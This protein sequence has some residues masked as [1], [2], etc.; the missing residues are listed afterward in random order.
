[1][2]IVRMRRIAIFAEG[3]TELQFLE[4]LILKIATENTVQ[5]EKRQISGGTSKP[6]SVVVLQSPGVPADEEYYVLLVDCQGDEQVRKRIGENHASLTKK[7][8]E[9]II[10]IRDVAPK[11]RREEISKLEAGLRMYIKS[12]LTPVEIF[13]TVM[14]IEAWFL[15]EHS[16]FERIDQLITMHAIKSAL[17]FDPSV[18]DTSL[19]ENPTSDLDLAYR[20]AGKGYEKGGDAK[21]MAALDY[22]MMYLELGNRVSNLGKLVSSLDAFFS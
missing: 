11:Y 13:L 3:Y 6:I 10:G 7:G 2:G 17:G 16:H 1:M 14:E 15:A 20:I 8:Y 19:R 21:T 9:K 18:D 5:V 4:Q 22:E 12:S